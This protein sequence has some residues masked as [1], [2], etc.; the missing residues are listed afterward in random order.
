MSTITSMFD[1]QTRLFHNVLD[2]IAD[3][4]AGTQQNPNANHIKFLAGHLVYTRMMLKDFAGLP[5]DARFAPFAKNMDAN[6]S[7]LPMADIMA[8]WDEI[9]GP[10]GNALKNLPA[11]VLAGPGP[12]AS[13]MG[14]TMEEVLG[15]FMHHEAYHLG[16]L[17]LL[18][19]FAGQEAM[20]YN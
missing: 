1:L 15:F 4:A 17:G 5:E 13:P 2:G 16:Q 7:Y 19:K 6:G 11:E 12:F 18:R 10:L 20:K 3:D 14:A 8:K 9:A